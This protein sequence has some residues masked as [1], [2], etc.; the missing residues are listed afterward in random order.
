MAPPGQFRAYEALSCFRDA[1]KVRH[2]ALKVEEVAMFVFS[3]AKTMTKWWTCGFTTTVSICSLTNKLH[4]FPLS[5]SVPCRLMHLVK[6]KE[7][8][9]SG[10]GFILVL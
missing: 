7:Q 5:V 6:S 10:F 9:F 1:T 4:L 8:R 3:Q 2:I